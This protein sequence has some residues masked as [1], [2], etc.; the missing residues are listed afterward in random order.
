MLNGMG[1]RVV[2]CKQRV[3][4]FQSLLGNS[5]THFLRLV[6]NDD[7]SV[8]LDN[9][10][11]ATR[12]ELVT[13]GVNNT[14][15]FAS[16]IFFQRGSESLRIDNH[17]IDT[18]VGGKVIQLVQVGAIVNEE[19]CFLSVMLHEMISSNFKSL[20]NTLTNSDRRDNDN[21]FAPTVLLVQLE[22]GLDIYIGLTSTGLHFNIKAASAQVL[23]QSF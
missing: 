11:R 7:R 22:H 15:F 1:C 14:S 18:R 21:E 5:T 16:S 3:K 20:F 23:N 4:V 10:N 2:Q 6:Q 12:T 13:L 8:C 19:T 17:H 9:I